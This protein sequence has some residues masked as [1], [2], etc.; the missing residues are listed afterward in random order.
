MAVKYYLEEMFEPTLLYGLSLAVIGVAA[1]AHY[2]RPDLLYGVLAI[3]GSVLAQ[4]SVNV[5]SDYFDYTSGLDRELALKKKGNLSGG[6]SLL[7]KGLI[8]PKQTIALGLILF[9]IAGAIGIYLLYVR[10]QILPILVL[11]AFTILLY[12]KVVK[13]I[14]YLSEPLCTVNYTLI[15]LGSFI[16]TSSTFSLPQGLIFSLIPAGILLGGDALYVNEVPDREIDKKYNI[17]H[18]VVMLKSSN[19]IG[20]Y[21]LIMQTAAYI[22]LDVGVLMKLLPLLTIACLVTFPA[23]LY[24]FRGLYDAD[25]KKYGAYLF[26]HTISS[27]TFAVILSISLIWGVNT[28]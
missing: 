2:G 19:K 24:V 28:L 5:I 15:A 16:V 1:A 7:A 26:V 13:K 20:L 8:K 11:A 14:P 9:T 25:S 21:Y 10:I 23:T 27:I 12:S 17:K 4:S 6:S 3:I 18:S 22:L